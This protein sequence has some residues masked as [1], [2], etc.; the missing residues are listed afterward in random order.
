MAE[1]HFVRTDRN[2]QVANRRLADALTIDP[3]FGPRRGVEID[4]ALRQVDGEAGDFPGQYLNGACRAIAE[5]FVDELEVVLAGREHY[6]VGVGRPDDAALFA[7]LERE[8]R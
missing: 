3:D 4:D 2:R 8:W 6:A 5:C 7:N 1:H